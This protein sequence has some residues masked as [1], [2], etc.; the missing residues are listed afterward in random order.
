MIERFVLKECLSFREAVLEFQPGLIVFSGPSGSGKSVLMRAILSSVGLDDPLAAL[1]ESSVTWEAD[2]ALS[3]LVNE[4]PNVLRE[5][6]R[7]KARYF[8]NDQS[9]SRAAMAAF[10]KAHLR[11]LSLKDY[12]DF[13]SSSLI[14]LIDALVSIGDETHR[15]RLEA[16]HKDFLR[17]QHL[18]HELKRLRAEE[19]RLREQEEFARFEVQKIDAID[20][21]ADEYDALLSVKKDLSRKEK[22]EENLEQAQ[23]LFEHEHTVSKVLGDLEIDAGFFDDAMNDL[24]A[25]FDAARERF[26]ELEQTD[27]ESV[28]DRLEVLSELKRRYGSIEEALSYRDKK[29]AEL[30]SYE[31]LEAEILETG[32]KADALYAG[33][34][35]AA[36]AI[37]MA[38]SSA[39]PEVNDSINGYLKQLYLDGAALTLSHG[40]FTAY[41]QDGATL[42]LKGT[43]LQRISAGEFNRLR[44]ALLA[45]KSVAMKGQQGVLMLDEIDANLS[46]EESMSVA[47]VLRTLSRHFQIFVISHQPQLTAM[48]EQHF[49]ITRSEDSSARELRTL[50][51]R[52]EEI[53]RI[54]SGDTITDEA[55][56]LA[57]ELLAASSQNEKENPL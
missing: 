3:G 39:L 44:L 28:L 52:T 1:S 55:R 14:G 21:R 37:S 2:H 36:K 10:S 22:L 48:G 15:Q 35:E 38:R 56:S 11:H 57:R 41:G 24:R 16:Y 13:E 49:L 27:I 5:V 6:K 12:S 51:E 53:A 29:R 30:D 25:H 19:I 31:S 7:E 42:S 34:T 46:G 17:F 45:V 18:D 54:V 20:P 47:R 32:K 33:L 40:D 50:Q 26:G 43:P 23:R 9:I 4:Q 8:F